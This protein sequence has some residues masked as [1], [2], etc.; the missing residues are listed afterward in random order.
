M[1]V[2]IFYIYLH[3][4]SSQCLPTTQSEL[5]KVGEKKQL[6]TDLLLIMERLRTNEKTNGWTE[7][8]TDGQMHTPL[9]PLH[10]G[11]DRQ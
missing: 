4:Y 7:G 10:T 1:I 6:V 9:H 5:L 3:D 2:I 11:N 8:R